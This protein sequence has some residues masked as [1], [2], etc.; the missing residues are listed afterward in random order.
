MEYCL[1]KRKK[2]SEEVVHIIIWTN[3]KNIIQSEISHIRAHIVWFHLTESVH[4]R[5]ISKDR[6]QLSDCLGLMEIG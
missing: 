2:K 4:N 1:A 3:L 6:K 5:Q